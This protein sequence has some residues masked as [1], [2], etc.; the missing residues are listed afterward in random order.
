MQSIEFITKFHFS[1]L[2]KQVDRGIGGFVNL[3]I[4]SERISDEVEQIREFLKVT[5]I[6][7]NKATMEDLGKSGDCFLTRWIFELGEGEL[8]FPDFDDFPRSIQF[9]CKEYKIIQANK[10]IGE[11]VNV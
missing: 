1:P 5:N 7:A 10:A 6:N 3:A 2:K 4:L 11:A 8:L 9:A